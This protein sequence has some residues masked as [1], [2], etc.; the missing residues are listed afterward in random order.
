MGPSS[1]TFRDGIVLDLAK[2]FPQEHKLIAV[3]MSG[4]VESTALLLL[5]IERYGIKNI[6]VFTKHIEGRRDWESVNATRLASLIGVNSSNIHILN[7]NY[8]GFGLSENINFMQ[9]AKEA[10]NY[11]AW[12]SGVN[13]LLFARTAPIDDSL[14]EK[15]RLRGVYTP[16]IKLFKRHTI[17]ISYLLHKEHFLLNTYSCTTQAKAHCGRCYCCWERARGFA[18]LNLIDKAIYE[19][20]WK[21][22]LAECFH[23]NKH[24]VKQ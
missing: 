20:E 8:K 21:N 2:E 15:N 13:Q 7:N 3:S 16:F 1:L 11:D 12:F 5:L 9:K 10:V 18:E 22:I 24:I 6:H 23:S 17:E 4:G 19:I 14:I